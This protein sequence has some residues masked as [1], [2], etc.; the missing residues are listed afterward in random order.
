MLGYATWD[1]HYICH[2]YYELK[3][4]DKAIQACTQALDDAGGGYALYWRGVAYH[5]L[6]RQDQALQDPTKSADSDDGFAPYSAVTMS[7]IY[8]DRNDNQNALNVL[9]KYLFLYDA[10]RTEKSQ[11]AVA[12]N[13]RCYAYMQLNDLKKALDDCTHSLEFGSIPDAFRKKQELEDRLATRE[14]SL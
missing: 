11:V 8:F 14:K 10:N 4:Y 1:E 6:N 5:D 7:M 9:N 12:Y 2:G 3:Q 13:N